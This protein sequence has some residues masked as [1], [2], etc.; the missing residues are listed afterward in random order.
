MMNRIEYGLFKILTELD[1]IASRENQVRDFLRAEYQKMGYEV[2]NDHLGSIFAIKRSHAFNPFKV[3]VDAHMDE[4]GYIIGNFNDDGTMELIPIGGINPDEV[5]NQSVRVSKKHGGLV[6][7]TIHKLEGENPYGLMT[8]NC[9]FSSK[10]EALKSGINFNDMVTF[11]TEF[12]HTDN[13]N[14]FLGKA[15]DDRYGIVL[16]IELLRELKDVDLPFDLYVGGSVQEEVGLRSASAIVNLIKPDLAIELDCSRASKDEHNL[17]HLG[18]GVLIRFYDRGMVAFPELLDLQIEACKKTGSD[19]QYFTTLGRTNA[20]EIMTARTGVPTLNH[21][22]CARDIHTAV[23]EMDSHDYHAAKESLFYLL[24]NL[25][26]KTLKNLRN[27][28]K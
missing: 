26:E 22:I 14:R 25:D 6:F 11:V 9:G 19:Y 20:S 27:Y 21:C 2:I 12:Q 4:V 15:I 3:M 10:E 28:R 8:L 23:A 7:G 18:Q 1:A 5:D 16:G 24:K 17:G 13:E